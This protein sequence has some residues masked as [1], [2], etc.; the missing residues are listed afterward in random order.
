MLQR[1]PASYSSIN[2]EANPLIIPV[3]DYGEIQTAMKT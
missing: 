3:V 2:N 1:I